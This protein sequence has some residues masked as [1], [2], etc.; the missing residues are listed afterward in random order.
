MPT[1]APDAV[2]E[3]LQTASVQRASPKACSDQDEPDSR[4]RSKV[5]HDN[6]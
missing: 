1:R 5:P 3:L 4:Q 6:K 2:G